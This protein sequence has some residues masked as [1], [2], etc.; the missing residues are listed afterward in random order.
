MPMHHAFKSFGF[1]GLVKHGIARANFES[2]VGEGQEQLVCMLQAQLLLC[3]IQAT[4]IV[5][6]WL[7][8]LWL[9]QNALV[10]R[11]IGM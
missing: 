6:C 4:T 1:D 5:R 9:M 2:K 11:A 7:N 8:H 3:S 10:H